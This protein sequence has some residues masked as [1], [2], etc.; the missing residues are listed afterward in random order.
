M[1]WVYSLKWGRGRHALAEENI[2]ELVKKNDEFETGCEVQRRVPMRVLKIDTTTRKNE[3]LRDCRMSL[4][5]RVEE[6]VPPRRVLVVDEKLRALCGQERAN[7]RCVT[8]TRGLAKLMPC[9]IFPVSCCP[10]ISTP[11]KFEKR[12]FKKKHFFLFFWGTPVPTI[13]CRSYL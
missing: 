7:L 3:L 11:F 5:G 12:F 1:L 4:T 8:N 10:V 6:R 2:G 13:I 9:H